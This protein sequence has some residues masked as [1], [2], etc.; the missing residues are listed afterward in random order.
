MCKLIKVSA[1]Y[2]I[3]FSNVTLVFS[4]PSF[5]PVCES[6]KGGKSNNYVTG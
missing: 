6:T 4:S 1:I 3:D 2:L 5:D